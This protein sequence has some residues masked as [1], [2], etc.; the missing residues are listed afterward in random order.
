MPDYAVHTS[1]HGR[2]R[3]IMD[4]FERMIRSADKFGRAGSSAFSRVQHGSD[5]AASS[6]RNATKVGYKFGAI[7][8]GILAA[9]AIRG[10]L[11]QITGGLQKVGTDFLQ[12]DDIIIGAVARFDDLGVAVAEP[13][14][15]IERLGRKTR[16]AVVGTRFAAVSAANAVNE[17]AKAG[18][19]SEAALG[20]LPNIMAFAT[21]GQEDLAEATK[22][23]SEILGAFGLRSANVQDQLRNHISLNDKLTKAALLSTGG[24]RDMKE[25]METIAPM[26]S[27]FK[28]GVDEALALAVVLSNAGIAGTEAATAIKRAQLNIYG[29]KNREELMANGINPVDPQTGG[30]RKFSTVLGEIGQKLS[31]L[32]LGQRV[33]IL[34]RLFGVYGI[35]GQLKLLEGLKSVA[36]YE[37]KIRDAQGTSDQVARFQNMSTWAKALALGNALMEKGFQVLEK[38]NGDGKSGLQGLIERVNQFKVAPMVDFL[39]A[40]G[41]TLGVLYAIIRPFLPLMPYLV[42]G[43]VAWNGVLKGMVLARTAYHIG[44][45]GAAMVAGLGPMGAFT[46]ALSALWAAVLPFVTSATILTGAF[47]WV[48]AVRSAITGKDN[49]FSEMA[50]NLGI[51]PKLAK[52]EEGRVIGYAS[53]QPAAAPNAKE[54]EARMR[55]HFMG[56]LNVAGAPP[57]STVE[58]RTTGAPSIPMVML[59]AQ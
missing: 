59:G 11:G 15:V 34:E 51:V 50:Q 17:L 12:F 5:R 19:T 7:V 37:Q 46:T 57:G 38:F 28:G 2:D 32:P 25:T 13:T 10:G 23:S 26:T 20:I 45:I 22:M 3:G 35:G 30:L 58:S 16:D 55:V 41:Q 36:E 24:L 4:A 33:P 31:K 39:R 42:A 44:L 14:K 56:Q 52:D 47:A 48:S 40:T 29:G 6:M 1:F 49:I 54:A 53:D 27:A 8:K 9:N 18:Y 43:W 21:A